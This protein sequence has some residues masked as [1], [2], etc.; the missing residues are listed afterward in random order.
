MGLVNTVGQTGE[1]LW[2]SGRME[3]R[4]EKVLIGLQKAGAKEAYGK[5]EKESSGQKKQLLKR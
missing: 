1:H 2:E 5:M 3:S 4:M